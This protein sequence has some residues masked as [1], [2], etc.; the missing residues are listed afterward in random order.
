MK[1]KR[2]KTL[3]GKNYCSPA[4]KYKTKN[5]SCYSDINLI[6][7]KEHYNKVNRNKIKT[8]K[9]SK[10]WDSIDN[11]MSGVCDTEWCWNFK[12]LRIPNI[13]KPKKPLRWNNNPNEWLDS[14]NII[15]VMKQYEQTYNDFIFIG[16][17]PIDFDLQNGAVCLIHSLCNIS[18]KRLLKRN[19]TK[20]G[21]IFN[22]DTHDGPGSHWT[23]LYLDTR[24]KQ[25]CYFDSYGMFPEKSIDTLMIK[26]EEQFKES[27]IKMKRVFNNT[28][29]Q[30]KFS[31]CGV[32]CL[33][34]IITMLKTKKTF[35]KFCKDNLSDEKIFMYRSKYFI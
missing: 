5:G 25:I 20:I 3:K 8:K 7:M 14:N 28:R 15:S 29:H 32:Y 16:P 26:L 34:F 9:I 11:K 6:E 1:K 21:I 23:A 27:G 24:R 12:L 2:K 22:L 17:V 19:K 4:V 13:F 18:V 10:L 31:E 33:H 30:Y 35:S